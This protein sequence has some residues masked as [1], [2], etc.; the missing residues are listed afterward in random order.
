MNEK[1]SRC[2]ELNQY[3]NVYWNVEDEDL[4]LALVLRTNQDGVSYKNGWV[5]F[6]VSVNG[7]MRGADIA[8]AR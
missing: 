8:I 4:H 3:Y 5:G 1:F 2:Q 7:G 6:G